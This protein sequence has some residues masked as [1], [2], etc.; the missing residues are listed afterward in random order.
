MTYIYDILLNFNSDLI[1]YFE[2][3]DTDKV[4]Y[5][6]KTTLFK[7]S[8]KTLIDII[9]NDILFDTSFT[10]KIPKYEMNGLK[11]TLSVC[12]LTNGLMALGVLIKKQKIIGLSRMLLDEEREVLDI[13]ERLNNENIS[14]KIINK[15]KKRDYSLTRKE[16]ELVHSL[17]DK[18]NYLY[19]KKGQEKLIYLYYE[20]TNKE[21]TNIDYIYK[22]LIDSL[23]N[24]NEKHIKLY[25]VLNLSKEKM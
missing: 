5:V 23:S 10:E 1:E 21:C 24:F 3:E 13:S 9:E 15:R 18:I 19:T 12:L 8:H 11:D 7:V 4:K 14:Y 2:W 6:K 20:Y 25:D 22:Y 16:Q 17:K